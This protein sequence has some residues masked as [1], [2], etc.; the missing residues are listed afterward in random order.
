VLVSIALRHV[1]P[2]VAA[3]GQQVVAAFEPHL[4]A[5]ARAV[6]STNDV[7]EISFSLSFFNPLTRV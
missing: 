7:S 6:R 4:V 1:T 3:A 2:D 5:A